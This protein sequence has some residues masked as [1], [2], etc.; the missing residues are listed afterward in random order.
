MGESGEFNMGNID[1]PG[2]SFSRLLLSTASTIDDLPQ[3][4]PLFSSNTPKML[5]FGDLSSQIS[6]SFTSYC[7]TSSASSCGNASTVLNNKKR[8][9][10]GQESG[11]APENVQKNGRKRN[12]PG[13]GP[14]TN[15][16][17]SLVGH[18]KVK[19]KREKLGDRITALQQLV[20]PYGKTDTASVLHEATGYIRFLQD[21]VKVLASPYL[22]SLPCSS[23]PQHPLSMTEKTPPLITYDAT[24]CLRSRGLCLVPVECIVDIANNNG[25]DFW[26][27]SSSLST[28]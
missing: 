26:S 21:Q 18:A 16:T 10:S 15:T 1:L 2:G 28:S 3:S 14:T 11:L 5:C 4:S 20:C 27:S 8:S 24:K 25:A 6:P 12:K 17:A 13:M 9:G 19:G 22:Q 23:S 7:A